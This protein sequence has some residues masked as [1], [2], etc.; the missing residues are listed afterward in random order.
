MRIGIDIGGS[1]IGVGIVDY[2]GK[3]KI[4]KDYEITDIDKKNMSKTLEE[5]IIK[6]IKEVLEENKSNIKEIDLIGISSAG[7]VTEKEIIKATN[8][9]IY[10]YKIVNMLKTYFNVPIILRN[11]AKCAAVAEKLFGSLKKYDD[12]IFLSVGTG[13]GGAAFLKGKLLTPTKLSGFEFGHMIIQR[14]GIQCTCGKKGCLETYTSIRAFKNKII[15]E[16]GLVKRTHGAEIVALLEK[17]KIRKQCEDIIDEYT[18][19]LALGLSN[20][21]NIFEPQVICLGGSFSYYQNILLQKTRNKIDTF[22]QY[23]TEIE[24]AK[25]KNDAGIIGATIT[26]DII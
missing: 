1:H 7:T 25:F 2:N 15:K 22:N 23:K 3:I 8:L 20:I 18:T 19:Y 5:N 21:I 13:V 9:N 17:D 11:D 14:N 12:A 16:L 10:N 6:L 26:D 24:I 4:K